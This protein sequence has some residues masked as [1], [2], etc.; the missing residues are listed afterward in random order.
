MFYIPENTNV[1]HITFITIPGAIS[2]KIT[3]TY[4][5]FML[6]ELEKLGVILIFLM[7]TRES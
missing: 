4:L 7:K 1:S 6:F 2:L 5:N 3:K